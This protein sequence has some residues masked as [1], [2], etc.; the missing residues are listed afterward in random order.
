MKRRFHLIIGLVT[1]LAFVSACSAAPIQTPTPTP[2]P[3][4]TETI[5]PSETVTP[6]P[7]QAPSPSATLTSSPTVKPSDTATVTSTP[8]PSFAGFAVEYVQP[9]SYGLLMGFIVPGIKENLRLT[10]NNS[11]YKCELNAKAPDRLYCY[12]QQFAQGQTVK[13][14]FL[15][16]SGDDTPV[17]ETTYKLVMIG[18]PTLNPTALWEAGKAC[19][20]RGV[21]VTCETEY[22]SLGD[23]YCIVSTC[24]DLCGYYKSVNT[25]PEGSEHNGIFQMTGTPP[26]PPVK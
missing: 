13:L 14:V 22:R 24:S 10:V 25:C 11:E 1:V 9:A 2:A 26:L 6:I 12:G 17:F 8:R 5:R 20:I 15:P 19:K 16:L 3:T 18:T 7:T 23:T 4:V 21:H